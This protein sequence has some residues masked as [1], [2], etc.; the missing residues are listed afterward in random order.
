MKLRRD[1]KCVVKS[2]R[3]VRTGQCKVAQHTHPADEHQRGRLPVRASGNNNTEGD[4]VGQIL[5]KFSPIQV[6]YKISSKD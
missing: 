5:V 1:T 2:D 6:T 3:S 4:R